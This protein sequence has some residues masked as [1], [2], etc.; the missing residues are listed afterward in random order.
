[1]DTIFFHQVKCLSE[2]LGWSIDK[3]V[4]WPVCVYTKCI[5]V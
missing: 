2:M 3:A 4:V 1:M 5:D